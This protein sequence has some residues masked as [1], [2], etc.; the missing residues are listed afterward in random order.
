MAT[1]IS[2][3]YSAELGA[4]LY[5]GTSAPWSSTEPFAWD[6]MQPRPRSDARC[7]GTR[8]P[9]GSARDRGS[10]VDRPSGHRSRPDPRRRRRRRRREFTG[11]RGRPGLGHGP[12]SAGESGRPQGLGRILASLASGVLR[13]TYEPTVR[14]AVLTLCPQVEHEGRWY[15]YE[16]FVR[17]MDV[18]A[19]LFSELVMVAPLESGPPPPFWAP[20]EAPERYRV[21][22][23]RHDRGRGLEQTPTGW[24]EVPTMVGAI[25][26]GLRATDACLLRAPRRD[27]PLGSAPRP[28]VRFSPSREVRRSVVAL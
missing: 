27:R 16:P 4:G 22:A 23:F 8:R 13:T 24:Q 18:W 12:R 2:L 9:A 11:D 14:L 3:P 6:G 1:G 17:E 5:I 26:Q 10:G 20:Y 25:W 28:G 15:S 19:R 7:L 21:I